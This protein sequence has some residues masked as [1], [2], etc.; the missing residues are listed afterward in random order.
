[1][2]Y[3]LYAVNTYIKVE[4]D[5]GYFLWY[6]S[7]TFYFTW[8]KLTMQLRIW[9]GWSLLKPNQGEIEWQPVAF[10]QQPKKF[11]SVLVY[12]LIG[13]NRENE[14]RQ[15]FKDYQG[16]GSEPGIF[17]CLF[18]FSHKQRH[19]PF[20]YFAMRQFFM[21]AFCSLAGQFKLIPQ[22]QPKF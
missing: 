7:R 14:T 11:K 6:V 4:F 10:L 15:F 17:Q 20:G 9:Q 19:R 8:K 2:C 3:E 5:V 12:L 22:G 13:M 16:Q 21:K 18:I 1:M